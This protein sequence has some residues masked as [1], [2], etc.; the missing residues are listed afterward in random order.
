VKVV[1]RQSAPGKL[2][3]LGEYSVLFGHPAVV[4]AVDRRARVHLSAAT[5]L[6]F[7]VTAPAVLDRPC[8]F[9][10]TEQGVPQWDDD[11]ASSR[12]GLVANVLASMTAAGL[13]SRSGL[14]PFSALLDSSQF[15]QRT[16]EGPI[17][18]GLG[19]SSALTVSFASAVARWS[20][21]EAALRRPMHWLRRLV[22]WHRSFQGGRGSGVDLA[23]GLLGGTLL[24]QLDAGGDVRRA[25]AIRLPDELVMRFVW[26]GHSAATGDFLDRL[27]ERM[28]TGGVVRALDQLG[29]VATAGIDALVAARVGDF[30]DAADASC[31]GMDRLGRECDLAIVSDVHR[32]LRRIARDCG[33]RYKPSGAG[34][35]DIGLLLTDDSDRADAAVRAVRRAGFHVV[36]AGIDPIGLA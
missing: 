7:R 32:R 33:T 2:V 29:A 28:A 20:G 34:G 16:A 18:L 26:S 27:S 14:L 4:A 24:Y 6:G 36:D 17:K 10:L 22:R 9:E 13:I 31:D 21:H 23:A 5:D 30:L 25:E 8:R 3:L 12:L 11:D 35:G 19:S 15:F 1:L